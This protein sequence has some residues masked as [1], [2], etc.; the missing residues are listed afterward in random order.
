MKIEQAESEVQALRPEWGVFAEH[1]PRKE[2]TEYTIYLNLPKDEYVVD[3]PRPPRTNQKGT[4]EL[5]LD[6]EVSWTVF[7][8]SSPQQIVDMLQGQLD[9]D[10]EDALAGKQLT[11]GLS[12]RRRNG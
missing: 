3:S 6:F 12:I 8:Q 1:K 10:L 7:E 11:P 5:R 4:W 2:S 9:R